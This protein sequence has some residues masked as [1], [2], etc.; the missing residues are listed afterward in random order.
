M[1]PDYFIFVPAFNV[2]ATLAGVLVRILPAVMARATVLVFDAGSKDD[3][4]GV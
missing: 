1:T 3:T 4:C 2:D